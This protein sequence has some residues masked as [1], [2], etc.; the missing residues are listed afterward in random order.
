[1]S[2][3]KVYKRI[4]AGNIGKVLYYMHSLP[5]PSCKLP[6]HEDALKILRDTGYDFPP[7]WKGLAKTYA[8][9][10]KI[11]YHKT[12]HPN[13]AAEKLWKMG[14]IKSIDQYWLPIN[15]IKYQKEELE[16]PINDGQ[17]LNLLE[18]YSSSLWIRTHKIN[19]SIFKSLFV[20]ASDNVIQLVIHLKSLIKNIRQLKKH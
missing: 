2:I 12:S 19:T 11:L 10:P 3:L 8:T 6:N 7:L 18:Q 16:I 5:F 4:V 13:N 14:A 9:I 15:L 17:Y 20:L 1:M